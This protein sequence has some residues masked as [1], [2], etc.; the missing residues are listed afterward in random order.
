MKKILIAIP[1]LNMVH[2]EFMTCLI[3]LILHK[4]DG[5]EIYYSVTKDSMTYTARIQL[6]ETALQSGA[7]YVLWIDSD[8]TF[9]ADALER[10]LEHDKDMVTGLYFQRRG[11]HDPVIY[12]DLNG[13]SRSAYSDYPQDSLFKVAACGFGLV[14]MKSEVIAKVAQGNDGMTFQPFPGIG[15]DLS[16]CYRW[17]AV[18][19]EIFCDSTLKLGHLGDYE[20]TEVDYVSN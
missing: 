9:P 13:D 5:A 8:M 14:L 11:K 7:D 17:N 4:I 16:F 18:G 6:A 2:A 1:M 3:R 19:G 10:L 15:E 20:Y 12:S